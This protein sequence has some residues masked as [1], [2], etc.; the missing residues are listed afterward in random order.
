MLVP[1]DDQR[2]STGEHDERD[3]PLLVDVLGLPVTL[4]PDEQRRVELF[5]R[6]SPRGPVP[7]ER[8]EIH[9]VHPPSVVEPWSCA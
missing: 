1:V 7:F 6:R 3:L 9:D 2:S 8:E 5:A 4:A